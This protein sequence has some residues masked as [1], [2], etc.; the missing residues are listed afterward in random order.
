MSEVMSRFSNTGDHHLRRMGQFLVTPSVG[1]LLVASLGPLAVTL[2]F[3]LLDYRLLS[4]DSIHFA[5]LANY[6]ALLANPAFI[7]AIRNTIVLLGS[8][9]LISVLGGIGVAA[10][11]DAAS[12]GRGLLRILVISPFFVMP[13][14]SALSWKNLIMDPVS[15]LSTY[16]L[17]LV[18]LPGYDWFGNS[19]LLAIAL[20][21]AWQWLP[22]AALIFIT[23]M[24][25]LDREQL[26]AARLDGASS[27]DS[28]RYLVMPHL[29][30]PIAIVIMMET[31]FL[32]NTFAEIFVTTGG[33][34]ANATTNLAF[35]VYT[36]AL[37][38]YD[39]GSASAAGVIA[40]IFA[41]IVAIFMVRAVGKSLK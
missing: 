30:R 16:A 13:T 27:F 12:F 18:G 28:F 8:V 24:Q 31:I 36:Q 32:L 4:P 15:G 2:W 14:V 40:V 7:E 20:I 39:V 5:G 10:L 33:G 35:L 17:N 6:W 23:A 37:L 29:A 41:N 19:P 25:S 11:L 3:S 22:F 38:Q 9:L 21:V 26:E 34:P 1:F